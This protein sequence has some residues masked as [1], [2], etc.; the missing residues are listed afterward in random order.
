MKNICLEVVTVIKKCV[1]GFAVLSASFLCAFDWPQDA[2]LSDSFYSYF[3]QYR[4]GTISSS[5]VFSDYSAVKAV[6]DGQMMIFVSEHDNDMGWFN[7]TLG[8]AV[9]IL[10]ADDLMTVYGNLDSEEVAENIT[11]LEAVH[12]GTP[13]GSSGNSGWSQGKSCLEF[14]VID[15][16]QHTSVNPRILMPR[17]GKEIPLETG[18]LSVISKSGSSSAV[19]NQMTLIAGQYY[20]YRSVQK[21]A[22][23]YKTSVSINGARVETI[24]YDSLKQKDMRLCVLGNKLYPVETVYPDNSRQ[25]IADITLSPGKN[26]LTVTDILGAEKTADYVL[27]VR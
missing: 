3:G 9:V 19:W 16:R 24:S 12:T 6:D 14:Q 18:S 21:K 17:I 1:C 27:Y 11:R 10:H 15:T 22:I 2:V 4:G 25:L 13:L 26:V 8:N 23:P 7:S 5:L 20:F